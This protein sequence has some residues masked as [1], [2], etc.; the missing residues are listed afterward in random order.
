MTIQQIKE[1]ILGDDEFIYQELEQFAIY[2]NLKH[3]LRWGQ[4]NSERDILESVA[5]HIYGMH[6]MADYFLPMYLD[7]DALKVKRFITWHDMAEAI[8]DDMTTK[9]KTED[10][11]KAEF[12]AEQ[13]IVSA[14]P[15]HMRG[16]LQ[17]V[18]LGFEKLNSKEARFVKAL[19]KL[20]PIFHWYFLY[21][22]SGIERSKFVTENSGWLRDEYKEHR[23][24]YIEEFGLVW[25]FDDILT[26]ITFK[27]GCYKDSPC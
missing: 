6:L 19:D 9:T 26:E 5:E 23:R 8:V 14:A 10:H 1:K 25:R 27:A 7:L 15:I 11:K 24:Q 18:F 22:T 16:D 12:Q 17:D 20:E 4:N 3:T 13:E 2:Y 21:K